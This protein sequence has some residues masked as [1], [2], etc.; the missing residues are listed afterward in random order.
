VL[1]IEDEM[2]LTLM[3]ENYE[4]KDEIVGE[5]VVK[6]SELTENYGVSKSLNLTH[7]SKP[8]EVAGSILIKTEYVMPLHEGDVD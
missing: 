3:D 6:T 7:P 4:K 2:K 1:H 5:V 8:G